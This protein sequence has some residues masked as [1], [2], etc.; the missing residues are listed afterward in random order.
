MVINFERNFVMKKFIVILVLL[1]GVTAFGAATYTLP[2][3]GASTNTWGTDLNNYLN[4]V[5]VG[6]NVKEYGATGD[7]T[8]DDR[9]AINSAATAAAG[10]ML[11]FPAAT[12]AYK[13]SSDLTI[14]STVSMVFERGASLSIDD[15]FTVTID[16]TV[17]AG[18]HTIFSGDGVVV[19]N[20]AGPVKYNW[21][22]TGLQAFQDAI[23]FLGTGSRTILLPGGDINIGA[24]ATGVV[25]D[26]VVN[27]KGQGR[28]IYDGSEGTRILY[29]GSGVAITIENPATSVVLQDFQLNGSVAGADLV[30]SGA[31]GIKIGDETSTTLLVTQP[32]LK[33]IGIAW[34]AGN[35]LE[36]SGIVAGLFESISVKE[37]VD[38]VVIRQSY[39]GVYND[40]ASVDNTEIGLY[41]HALTA[42]QIAYNKF[43]NLNFTGNGYE[44][45]N[46]KN[47][48]GSGCRNNVFDGF[49]ME[50]S[51]AAA[52]RTDTYFHWK[53]GSTGFT[54]KA[55]RN[56]IKNVV[57][58]SFS[59]SVDA[60]DGTNGNRCIQL[61]GGRWYLE[62]LNGELNVS[63]Y[64]DYHWFVATGTTLLNLG[65]ITE[66]ELSRWDI[67][68]TAEVV[69]NITPLKIVP[70]VS[71]TGAT[72]SDT[73][74]TVATYSVPKNT[75]GALTIMTSTV[76]D[77]DG[78]DDKPGGT[79]GLHILVQ[80]N[81]TTGAA[82]AARI[83]FGGNTVAEI[84]NDNNSNLF[85]METW[86][87]NQNSAGVRYIMTKTFDGASDHATPGSNDATVALQAYTA[88]EV[89]PSAAA[90]IDVDIKR[91]TDEGANIGECTINTVFIERF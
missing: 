70:K 16:G 72:A 36:V 52:G 34:F 35:G 5:K 39:R 71:V 49:Q 20:G 69:A 83:T 51:Q 37:C 1:C 9:G 33:N 89:S 77:P 59:R 22:G 10:G 57:F 62:N 19:Y 87:W 15:T 38:G 12:V 60:W 6:I 32:Q 4:A 55:V 68:V 25:I 85:M 53:V 75:T 26:Q 27:I 74:E 30:A 76:I 64:G 79:A 17:E 43:T 78:N 67:P 8:T 58:S 21:F 7:G 44:A 48:V 42:G 29:T 18:W 13:I 46:I 56:T 66:R 88:I 65:N 40:I 24:T 80:G 2:T 81:R 73:Y 31:A 41:I 54:S 45:V 90:D 47:E 14:G 91:T 50:T 28:P 11:Y 61:Q 84:A 82:A 3:V 86:I 23:D 63:D